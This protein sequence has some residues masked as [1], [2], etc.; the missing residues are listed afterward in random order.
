MSVVVYRGEVAALQGQKF[1]VP[2]TVPLNQRAKWIESQAREQEARD[3]AALAKAE[4]D[5]E[6]Q[7]REEEL[8]SA[9][10]EAAKSG[11]A[12]RTDLN[13]LQAEVDEVKAQLETPDAEALLSM[14][15]SVMQAFTTAKEVLEKVDESIAQAEQLQS[16]AVELLDEAQQARQASVQTIRNQ[17][18]A[19]NALFSGYR[20][21][22]GDLEDQTNA[23]AAAIGLLNTAAE[24]NRETIATAAN[25]SEEAVNIASLEAKKATDE[26]MDEILSILSVALEALG[27]K[28][29]DL[30]LQMNADESTGKGVYLT[31]EF[32]R[33]LKAIHSSKRDARDSSIEGPLL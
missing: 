23:A 21:S 9:R 33:R 27:V 24:D 4:A 29:E 1:D 15:S 2:E 12:F 17:Q 20:D 25:I 14:N 26:A 11:E 18:E 28:E 5:A 19:I 31:R 13:A 6:A 8:L 3:A 7:A 10:I 22:L 32:L 30:A 16:S